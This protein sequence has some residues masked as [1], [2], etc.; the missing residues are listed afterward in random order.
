MN[1]R[2]F[3]AVDAR[4]DEKMSIFVPVHCNTIEIFN[5]NINLNFKKGLE[6][7]QQEL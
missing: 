1:L 6:L 4:D 2:K 3:L 7:W 5:W